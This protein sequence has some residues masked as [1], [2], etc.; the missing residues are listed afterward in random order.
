V[1]DIKEVSDSYAR[2]FL[3]PKG[4]AKQVTTQDEKM[5]ENQKKKQEQQRVF[6]LE[7]RNGLFEKLNG[8]EFEFHLS[9]TPA[10]KKFGSI[11]EKE[12]IEALEKDIKIKFT[13]SDIELLG[14]HI[15]KPGRF[16]ALV[17]L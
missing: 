3:I 11:G 10:G 2:N 5:L 4:L 17:K 7:N 15:K 6:K 1:G 16:D 14:G 9:T 8:K 12:I 13:K